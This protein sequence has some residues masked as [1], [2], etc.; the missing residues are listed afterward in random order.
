MNLTQA[1][2]A[3]GIDS[4]QAVAGRAAIIEAISQ[5]KRQAAKFHPDRNPGSK[6]AEQK[7]LAAMDAR[8]FFE[9]KLPHSCPVCGVTISRGAAYCASHSRTPTK[10]ISPP[11]KPSPEIKR[12]LRIA[13]WSFHELKD[14]DEEIRAAWFYEIEREAAISSGFTHTAWFDMS[15]RQK[16]KAIECVKKFSAVREIGEHLSPHVP[17][18]NKTQEDI[19]LHVH[20]LEI[21]WSLGETA[22]VEDFKNW[23]RNHDGE[24]RAVFWDKAKS[25][26]GKPPQYRSCLASLAIYRADSA[27]LKRTDAAKLLAPL[28]SWAGVKAIFSAAHWRTT[29]NN[30]AR[31]IAEAKAKKIFP[32]AFYC[33]SHETRF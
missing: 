30:A 23:L 22:I 17:T 27:G 8:K 33:N 10:Q 1:K 18:I 6:V 29:C 14:R 19:S 32:I 11:L 2:R 21:D 13:D 4:R 26:G 12:D 24:K 31:H 9:K 15:D 7:F 28:A 20:L 5:C 3:G 25:S 16:L